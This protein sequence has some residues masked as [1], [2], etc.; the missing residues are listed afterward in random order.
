M[1]CFQFYDD[2]CSG[3]KINKIRLLMEH[4]EERCYQDYIKMDAYQ[5]NVE[6]IIYQSSLDNLEIVGKMRRGQVTWRIMEEKRTGI[7][8]CGNEKH[9]PS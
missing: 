6:E 9:E 5:V 2:Q 8:T 1:M 4:E 7:Y 3:Y